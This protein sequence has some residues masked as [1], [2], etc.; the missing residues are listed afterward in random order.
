MTEANRDDVA[1]AT[2]V[3]LSI[4]G[5]AA[6]G[7]FV[8]AP[9]LEPPYYVVMVGAALLKATPGKAHR[10]AEATPTPHPSLSPL[11]PQL[12]IP[13]LTPTGPAPPS[14]RQA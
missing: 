11:A 5:F 9:A 14:A 1:I 4:V 6:A 10:R 2:G 12:S 7:Q 8:S 13:R 3:V